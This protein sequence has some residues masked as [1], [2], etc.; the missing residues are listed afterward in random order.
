MRDGLEIECDPLLSPSPIAFSVLVTLPMTLFSQLI[1]LDH[2]P[3]ESA[4]FIQDLKSV[5]F[6]H[7]NV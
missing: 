1:K 6:N 2:V 5:Y 4:L 7:A 3:C